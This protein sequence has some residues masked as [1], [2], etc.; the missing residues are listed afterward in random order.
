M[1]LRTGEQ[2]RSACGSPPWG[3]APSRAT[4]ATRSGGG[5]ARAPRT[6]PLVPPPCPGPPF[7][8]PRVLEL[9]WAAKTVGPG[10]SA[11]ACGASVGACERGRRWQW[12]I[13][14]ESAAY[15]EYLHVRFVHWIP[16]AYLRVQAARMHRVC[17]RAVD[18]EAI[19][20]LLETSRLGLPPSGAQSDATVPTSSV[21]QV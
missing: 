20:L 6:A 13:E 15:Y 21:T 16:P 4:G 2:T 18:V 11:I 8:W 7:R 1:R 12:A 19:E 9:L 3:H 5:G 17:A 10:P 14:L